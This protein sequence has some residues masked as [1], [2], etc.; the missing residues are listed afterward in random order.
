MNAYFARLGPNAPYRSVQQVIDRAGLD[1]LKGRFREALALPP[2]ERSDYYLARLRSQSMLRDALVDTLGR[3]RLDAL[4][5]PYSLVGASRVGEARVDGTNSLASHAGL[6]I[7]AQ[8]IARPYAETTP[9]ATGPPARPRRRRHEAPGD[10]A[11]AAGRGLSLHGR[12]RCAPICACT[13]VCLGHAMGGRR[14][15][16]YDDWRQD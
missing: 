9:P 5:L 3:H 7:A 12:Q 13:P 1:Q 11:A 2:P 16:V 15:P 14:A 4:L 6:P 8:L 10:H